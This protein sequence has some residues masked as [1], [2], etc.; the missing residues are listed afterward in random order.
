MFFILFF[1]LKTNANVISPKKSPWLFLTQDGTYLL[2]FF[3]NIGNFYLSSYS[4]FKN[5]LLVHLTFLV[6][7]ELLKGKIWESLVPQNVY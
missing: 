2:P 4:I 6:D 5:D 1:I 3:A 7:Y